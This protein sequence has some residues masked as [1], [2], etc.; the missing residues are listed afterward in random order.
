M[1]LAEM[2]V[3][4]SLLYAHD[5]DVVVVVVVILYDSEAHHQTFSHG[6]EAST[7]ATLVSKVGSRIQTTRK[8]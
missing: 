3:Y 8:S 5:L 2:M 6:E 7:W 1:T 4:F